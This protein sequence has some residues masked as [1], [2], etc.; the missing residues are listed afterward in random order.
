MSKNS[1]SKILVVD[2]E[3]SICQL[4]ENYA[5]RRGLQCSHRSK[6]ENALRFFSIEP[7]D[8]V[9]SD[10]MMPNVDGISFLKIFVKSIVK[11]L[12]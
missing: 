3:E 9:I 2:D 6:C 10:I 12:S 4:L 1:R 8:L 7:F 11:S 5:F